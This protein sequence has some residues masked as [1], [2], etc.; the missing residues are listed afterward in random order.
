MSFST[1]FTCPFSHRVTIQH[2]RLPNVTAN[3]TRMVLRSEEADIWDLPSPRS[4]PLTDVQPP[5]KPYLDF[6]FL[7]QRGGEAKL[8]GVV[9]SYS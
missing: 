1:L 2:E 6:R 9:S 7:A 3:V 8:Q 5:H 4:G